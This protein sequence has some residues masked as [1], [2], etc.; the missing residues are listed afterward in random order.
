MGKFYV[1]Q[2]GGISNAYYIPGQ[3]HTSNGIRYSGHRKSHS[4]MC[5]IIMRAW[6][7]STIGVAL[8]ICKMG[9]HPPA[10][11]C[12]V[13]TIVTLWQVI[14]PTPTLQAL[15]WVGIADALYTSTDGYHQ[16]TVRPK[17]RG[18]NKKGLTVRNLSTTLATSVT[19]RSNVISLR[20]RV[21]SLI[22]IWRSHRSYPGHC[23]ATMF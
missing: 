18:Q 17:K 9:I 6:S 13:P 4:C 3:Q 7:Y 22:C 10:E 23:D 11:T 5:R 2:L 8:E 12:T 21:W 16:L 20:F 19:N 1:V 15:S 14:P